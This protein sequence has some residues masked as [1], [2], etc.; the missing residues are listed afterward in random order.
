MR[1]RFLSFGVAKACAPALKALGAASVVVGV[2][3][4]L[5]GCRSHSQLPV[6]DATEKLRK[7]AL[8][9]VQFAAT[10]NGIGPADEASLAK[11][12]AQRNGLSREDAKPYFV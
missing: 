2:A 1:Y 10:N 7:L 9:Y 6:D 12:L 3:L 11:F 5:A 8:A 4:G